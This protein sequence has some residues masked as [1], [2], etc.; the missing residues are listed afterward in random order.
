MIRV[1]NAYLHKG[2]AIKGPSWSPWYN[3]A[4]VK[5]VDTVEYLWLLYTWSLMFVQSW[6]NAGVCIEMAYFLVVHFAV[7]EELCS[8]QYIFFFCRTLIY[9]F[10]KV[11][12]VFFCCRTLI[13]SFKKANPTSTGCRRTGRALFHTF[14]S[15]RKFF[16]WCRECRGWVNIFLTVGYCK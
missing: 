9:T 11:N 6:L 12:N 14:N 1:D 3:I 15:L 16:I 7:F 8:F 10:K 13:Y 2:G 5:W 4:V